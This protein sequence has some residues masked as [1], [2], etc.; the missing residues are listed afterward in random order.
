LKFK[1]LAIAIQIAWREIQRNL[2]RSMLTMLGIII[3]V[4]A[5][6][7]LMTLGTGTTQHVTQQ[8]ASLGSNLLMITSGKALGPIQN[9][10][11]PKFKQADAELLAREVSS[12][13]DVAPQA[14]TNVIAIYANKNWGTNVTGSTDRYFKVNNRQVS[15]GRVFTPQE[16]R[17][18]ATVCVI[19]ETLRGKLFGK[20]SPIG[21][22]IRL[23][24][25]SC[26]IIGLLNAKGQSSMGSDQDDI[27]ILPLKA[28]QRRISGTT[29]VMLIQVSAKDNADTLSVKQSIRQVMRQQRH[30]SVSEDDNFSVVDMKEI[31]GILSGTTKLMTSLLSAVAGISLLVGGVGIMNIMLVSVTERTREIGIRLAVGALESEILLQFLVEAV[32]LSTSGGLIGIFLAILV[33]II[34]AGALSIPLVFNYSLIVIAFLFSATLGVVFGYLPA[35]KA[36]RLDPISAL[37]YE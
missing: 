6:I 12:L 25:F 34:L 8:I 36:A 26:D 14:S 9:S 11:A 2:M 35:R 22:K 33:S 28:F 31:A 20:A 21:A 29:D 37:R 16:V 19:G 5:V 30:L 17:S 32:V 24:K 3:G 7:V 13:S 4:A 10:T 18:G 27:V 1:L 23:Q 15:E